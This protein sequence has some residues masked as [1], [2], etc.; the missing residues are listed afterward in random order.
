MLKLIIG[1]SMVS[2]DRSSTPLCKERWDCSSADDLC[3]IDISDDSHVTWSE[4]D[5]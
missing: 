1:Q 2:T 3:D 5:H 4:F